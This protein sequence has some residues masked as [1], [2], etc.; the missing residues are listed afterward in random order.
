MASTFG[1]CGAKDLF[2]AA[3]QLLPCVVQTRNAPPHLD[4]ERQPDN[5]Q[6][7]DPPDLPFASHVGHTRRNKLRRRHISPSSY[8]IAWRLT[9]ASTRVCS[10]AC[11]RRTSSSEIRFTVA[12][13]YHASHSSGD[14]LCPNHK[15]ATL[16]RRP[17]S[18]RVRHH[19]LTLHARPKS[20]SWLGAFAQI[21]SR[22]P[23]AALICTRRG[24]PDPHCWNAM[25]LPSRATYRTSGGWSS[26]RDRKRPRYRQHRAPKP[27]YESR[28]TAPN[29]RERRSQTT[30]KARRRQPRFC[31][32]D[33]ADCRDRRHASSSE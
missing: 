12:S 9:D 16:V 7:T 20:A 28:P 29:T 13:G 32:R 14:A 25:L 18:E 33:T 22:L 26:G 10:C 24:S 1:R 11:F 23:A 6:C 5:D 31:S 21:G 4:Q 8:V 2:P 17:L 3:F 30:V 15:K 19:H 27:H